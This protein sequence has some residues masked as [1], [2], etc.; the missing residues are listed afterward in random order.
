[1]NNQ[2][3]KPMGKKTIGRDK[4]EGT[5]RHLSN[6]SAANIHSVYHVRTIS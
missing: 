5:E 4:K 2:E 1:M 3:S 6:A